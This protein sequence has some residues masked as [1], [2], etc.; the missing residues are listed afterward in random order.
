[1]N[2]EKFLDHL[3]FL[4]KFYCELID[5]RLKEEYTCCDLAEAVAKFD[6]VGDLIVAIKS[7]EFN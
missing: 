3:D 5:E 7:G 6:L 4:Q 2:E 1:M